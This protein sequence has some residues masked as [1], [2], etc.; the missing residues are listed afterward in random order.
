MSL[1]TPTT[2]Q[3]SDSIL[4]QLEAAL[5]ASTPLLPKAFVRVLARVLGG[6][7]ILVY[8]Y[9]GWMF[10]QMFVSSASM[11][12]T[13]VN[14]RRIRPLVEWGRLIGVGDPR[15]ATRAEL[16]VEVTVEALGGSLPAGAQLLGQVNGVIYLT[17]AP[18]N[19][20]APTKTVTIRA[21]SDQSGGTGEGPIG[22]L[23]AG[24]IV[25][26]ASPLAGVAR[27]CTVL[28]QAVTGAEG[29]ADEAYRQRVIRRF[30]R[31]PQGGAYA[32]YQQWGEEAPGI[33]NVYP[34][35]GVPGV[36]DVYVEAT[37]ESS[38][39][40]D[41]I[42]TP[43]QLDAVQ[44]LIELDQD[45][46]ATRRPAT[47]LVRVHPITR[48][49]FTVRLNG[50][51]AP[52]PGAVRDAVGAAVDDLLRSREPFIV[53]LSVLPRRD[54]VTLAA[55]SGVADETASAMGATISS[56]ELFVGGVAVPVT[57]W[58]LTRGQKAKLADVL[59]G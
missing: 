40:D 45:G 52:D 51:D 11:R 39:S 4:A 2:K 37:P 12:E 19:L 1:S 59:L 17:T 29:E 18:I 20:D 9:A 42:P 6:V 55:V 35:T 34:Y 57:T 30:R 38:G 22:N 16:V 33:R 28:S 31:R 44:A 14:G 8:K 5:A 26:F 32:D 10:L 58:T 49:P 48:L 13:E 53:G 21:A 41:G 56:V 7:F 24:A 50:V 15:P 25:S 23:P 27:D 3:I 36:V 43:A 47:A 46:L 54:R